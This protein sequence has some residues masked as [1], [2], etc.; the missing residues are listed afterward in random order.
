MWIRIAA[1]LL[2]NGGHNYCGAFG[3]PVP[4]SKARLYVTRMRDLIVVMVRAR[5]TN[6]NDNA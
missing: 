2:H 4:F 5:A 3:E 1:I 6:R